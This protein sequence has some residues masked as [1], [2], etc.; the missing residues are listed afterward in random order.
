VKYPRQLTRETYT[1]EPVVGSTLT[2]DP[3]TYLPSDA[4]ITFQ[5]HQSD[6][7]PIAGATGRSYT[8]R[9][10]DVGHIVFVN[11]RVAHRG[12]AAEWSIGPSDPVRPAAG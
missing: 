3:G 9:P 10:S 7:G 6:T 5:W 2:V 4:V 12:V 1:G 8:L 11:I